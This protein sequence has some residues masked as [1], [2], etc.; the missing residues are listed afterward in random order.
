[1][2]PLRSSTTTS[3]VGTARVLSGIGGAVTST[4]IE[5]RSA[6]VRL[7]VSQV[8]RSR[9]S[10]V[11]SSILG[12]F[13]LGLCKQHNASSRDYA[14]SIVVNSLPPFARV[15]KEQRDRKGMSR[16]QLA[17]AAELSYPYISQL[18]TGLRKPSRNAARA[19]AQALDLS[20]EALERTIPGDV[21]DRSQ[22]REA[23][24]FS[25]QLLSG[26][27]PPGVSQLRVASAPGGGGE[28]AA[29]GS[30]EDLIGDILD[31]VEEF[32]PGE[33]LDVLAEVQKRAMQRMLD[34][35]R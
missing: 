6:E 4:S 7:G 29:P 10:R 8:K 14:R 13:R 12:S 25:E 24:Q 21:K 17:E 1:M 2:D 28:H 15:I 31:L 20:V 32:D 18:E 35:R 3:W 5:A 27:P 9:S 26:G 34:A 19:I 33:R 22:V 16:S 30:R 23:Q 11:V